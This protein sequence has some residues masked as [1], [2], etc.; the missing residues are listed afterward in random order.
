MKHKMV[1]GT[2]V[3][4]VGGF[5]YIAPDNQSPLLEAKARGLFRHKKM[6]PAVGDRVQVAVTA[7]ENNITEIYPRKNSFIRPPVVNVDV[8]LLV[9]AMT[10]PEPD[11]LLLDK[12]GVLAEINGLAPV[13]IFTKADLAEEAAEGRLRS[14]YEPTGYELLFISN[15]AAG[16]LQPLKDKITG[17]TAFLAGPSGVGKSTLANRLS[18]G[19]AMET[20]TISQKSGRGKHT[21]RHVELLPLDFGGYLLDTPGFSSLTLEK[22]T[23]ADNLRLYF[24]EF[25]QGECKFQNC[26][27]LSEP[28]CA[29]KAQVQA[30]AVANS[31]YAN[32]VSL[33]T[34]LI[35]KEGRW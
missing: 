21:T 1:D 25:A 31:R 18:P 2:I 30:G 35:D 27:H 32:Y 5:Y 6:K 4:G 34:D 22:E 3:K 19:I 23:D 33:E 8:A 24:P 7:S 26:R 16:E 20:G 10:D 29:V 12:L 17:Q 9:F 28:G 15:V 11:L 14:I 13:L